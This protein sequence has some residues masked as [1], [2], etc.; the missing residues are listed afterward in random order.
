MVYKMIKHARNARR[1]RYNPEIAA[2][3]DA[4]VA[5]TSLKTERSK[6]RRN[7]IVAGIAATALLGT[8]YMAL[9]G[10]DKVTK[11][12]E[13]AKPHGD[14][15]S[16][17]SNTIKRVKFSKKAPLI[18]G[19]GDSS[20]EINVRS[21]SNAPVVGGIWNATV[22]KWTDRNA[23]AEREGTVELGVERN[24]ITLES[25]RLPQK[26]RNGSEYGLRA[27]VDASKV[28]SRTVNP[29]YRSEGGELQTSAANDTLSFASDKGTSQRAGMATTLADS[30]FRRA[31]GDAI[32]P[33]LRR[34]AED[35]IRYQVGIGTVLE[36]IPNQQQSV[37]L[38]RQLS[39]GPVEVEFLRPN[40]QTVEPGDIRP[41]APAPNP[42]SI[43]RTLDTSPEDI[44]IDAGA[45]E[46]Q[47]TRTA[48]ENQIGILGLPDSRE[49]L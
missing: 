6:T 11:G 37:K 48:Y 42:E 12:A 22:G 28:Y 45:E 5:E 18:E 49:G 19:E 29:Q 4:R 44:H 43:S 13:S 3:G 30:T 1:Q 32:T 14:M 38:L 21:E 24:A 15:Q 9:K 40:G 46:C 17:I 47:F 16:E 31:C 41:P 25:V 35:Y 10:V 39:T 33:T 36:G 23:R 34:G 27:Y 7:I 8:G 20:A 2:G 26:A